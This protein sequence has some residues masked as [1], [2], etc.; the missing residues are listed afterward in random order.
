MERAQVSA[1]GALL[2]FEFAAN[3]F[4]HH[5]VRNIVGS[6]VYIGKGAHPPEWMAELLVARD[7]TYAA[8]T[9]SPNGLYLAGVRYPAQWDLPRFESVLPWMEQAF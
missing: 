1:Q 2:K 8:P 4:L 6:L 3:G 7:R 9:F 5:M